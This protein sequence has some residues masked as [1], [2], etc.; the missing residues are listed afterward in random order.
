MKHTLL[1]LVALSATALVACS[2]GTSVPPGSEATAAPETAATNTTNFPLYEG[3]NV[4][5]SKAFSQTINAGQQGTGVMAAGS[6]TYAGNEVIAGSSAKLGDLETWLRQQEK[7]PPSGFVAVA[8]PASMATVHTVALKNGM[9]FAIF[10][11][12]TNSKHGLIVV[13]MDPATAH[14]KLGPALMLV[15]KYQ[16][17]PAAMRQT[18]DSQLKQ[19]YGY[20]ASEFV[21]P[22]SPLGS[23][24]GAM[25]DFQNKDQRAIIII[26]ATK[27]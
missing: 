14:H 12:A 13:A 15:S 19:R 25:N 6:G 27:Q 20:T 5:A 22:G 17:L 2:K 10:H 18:I 3:S 7:Q 8:I 23:A 1:V 26:D 24:V 11:D 9:D 16:A 21:E 4:I